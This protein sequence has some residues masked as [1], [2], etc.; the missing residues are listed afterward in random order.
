[1]GERSQ[2][3]R[4]HGASRSEAGSCRG[5]PCKVQRKITLGR[6]TSLPATPNRRWHSSWGY[7]AL[8]RTTRLGVTG[9]WRRQRWYVTCMPCSWTNSRQR[10]AARAGRAEFHNKA[11]RT[12]S[13]AE[14]HRPPT[15]AARTCVPLCACREKHPLCPLHLQVGS[16]FPCSAAGGSAGLG[17]SAEWDGQCWLVGRPSGRSGHGRAGTERCILIRASV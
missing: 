12:G 13:T 5:S 8:H 16:G 6:P 1:M 9:S 2:A 11:L 17:E 7:L 14:L 4:L 10:N 3:D 15:S